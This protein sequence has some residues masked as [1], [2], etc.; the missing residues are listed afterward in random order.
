MSSSI[1]K[2]KETIFGDDDD[3]SNS[4]AENNLIT[5]YANIDTSNADS[6]IDA[7]TQEASSLA[8]QLSERPD[9][10]YNVDV[11]DN[12]ENN[13]IQATYQS[14]L[15]G[16]LPAFETASSDLQTTLA[17]QGLSVGSEAYQRATNDLTAQHNA[18]LVDAAYQSVLAGQDAYNDSVSNAIANAE[19]SN[20]TRQLAVSEI[21]DLL[22]NAVSSNDVA[23][24]T[25]TLESG[26]LDNQSESSATSYSNIITLL[27]TINSLM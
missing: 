24:N 21:Y 2:I 20:E 9:Y 7:L 15:N 11:S 22:E 16:L 19:L 4:V 23:A 18:A 13:A 17:N 25:Y 3:A 12:A 1:K 27:K 8:A 6:A 5:Y 26:I 14:Y 10:I